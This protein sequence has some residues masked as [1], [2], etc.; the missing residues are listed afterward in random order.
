MDGAVLS[1]AN[2]RQFYR[3]ASPV[4]HGRLL[5]AAAVA[6]AADAG[7]TCLPVEVDYYIN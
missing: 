6:A 2:T 1:Q 4:S 3:S 5:V 7:A